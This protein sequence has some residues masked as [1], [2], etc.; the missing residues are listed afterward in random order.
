MQLPLEILGNIT[1]SKMLGALATIVG[2]DDSL[3]ESEQAHSMPEFGLI[4]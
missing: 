2:V 4:H 1:L 3:S